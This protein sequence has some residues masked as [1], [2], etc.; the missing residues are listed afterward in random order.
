MAKLSSKD[1]EYRRT[2]GSVSSINYHFVF[3]PK[4]RKPVLVEHVARRLLEII[5]D[6]VSEHGWKLIA[7]EIMPDH[8]HMFLNAPTHESPAEIARWVKG[9]ASHHLRKEFPN[10]KKLPSLWT[11]TYFVASTGQVSTEVVKKYIENQKGK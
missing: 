2:E 8:V 5:F 10:L 11:P 3:V 4:R 1:Y 7:L 6:L 9:R